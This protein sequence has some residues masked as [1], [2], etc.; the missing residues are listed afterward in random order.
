[1][2]GCAGRGQGLTVIKGAGICP[3][4]KGVRAI[5]PVEP[6]D[7]YGDDEDYADDSADDGASGGGGL[8]RC[9]DAKRWRKNRSC[10]LWAAL[11]ECKANRAFMEQYCQKSC[12]KAGQLRNKICKPKKKWFNLKNEAD[13][14]GADTNARRGR[15]ADLLLPGGAPPTVAAA[16]LEQEG[17]SLRSGGDGGRGGGAIGGVAGM[18]SG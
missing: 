1:M 9:K 12:A 2:P 13:G 18:F 5:R 16:G 17:L 10:P 8:P 7:D 3:G 4:I 14:S 6:E 15:G 11:G